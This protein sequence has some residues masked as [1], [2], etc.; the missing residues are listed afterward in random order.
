MSI[1]R[2]AWMISLLGIALGG[3]WWMALATIE[4]ERSPNAR[5]ERANDAESDLAPA[6]PAI[7]ELGRAPSVAAATAP[8]AGRPEPAAPAP[9]SPGLGPER[10]SSNFPQRQGPVTELSQRFAGESRADKSHAI[11]ASVRSAFS[12]PI[13]PSDMLRAIE[14]RRSVCRAQL[15][16]SEQSNTGYV[17]GLTQAVGS[18]SAAVGIEAPG[19]ADADG[20]YPL[21][22][23]WSIAE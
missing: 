23:Y 16:W 18:Y 22:V 15:H 10:G 14:C 1:T 5:D 4:P 21:V 6:Q 11:E 20:R 2:P 13:I 7:A 19:A 3:A 9:S 12:D 8:D 17:L